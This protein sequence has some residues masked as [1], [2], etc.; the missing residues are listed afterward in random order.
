[1]QTDTLID[2]HLFQQ[3]F[4]TLSPKKENL[5]PIEGVNRIL[6]KIRQ[7][8]LSG[9][10][11]KKP[12]TIVAISYTALSIGKASDCCFSNERCPDLTQVK[13]FYSTYHYHQF[14]RSLLPGLAGQIGAACQVSETN[15]I[16]NIDEICQIDAIQL[17]WN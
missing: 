5:E 9:F 3:L 13:E 2:P 15:R 7:L 14:V 8:W 16:K 11:R 6:E 17:T 1:M 12:I 10:E 4:Y